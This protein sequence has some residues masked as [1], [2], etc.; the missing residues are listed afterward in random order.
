MMRQFF[1]RGVAAAAAAVSTAAHNGN[2]PATDVRRVPRAVGRGRHARRCRWACSPRRGR[3]CVWW[4]QRELAA[5]GGRRRGRRPDRAPFRRHAPGCTARRN[6]PLR[7]AAVDAHLWQPAASPLANRPA[8]V[9]R[10]RGGRRAVGG[11]GGRRPSRQWA[12]AAVRWGGRVY[13]RRRRVRPSALWRGSAGGGPGSACRVAGRCR[14]GGGWRPAE[15]QPPLLAALAVARGV[16]RGVRRGEAVTVMAARGAGRLRLA[17]VAVA[18]A[19][20]LSTAGR[21]RAEGRRRRPAGRR[22][23][24]RGHPRLGVRCRRCSRRAPPPGQPRET[25]FPPTVNGCGARR[26]GRVLLAQ[27]VPRRSRATARREA[28]TGAR[29]SPPPRCPARRGT[30]VPPTAAR[31]PP[32]RTAAAPVAPPVRVAH[33]AN[34]A[35]RVRPATVAAQ[36]GGHSRGCTAG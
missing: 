36:G 27:P 17:S 15:R 25:R 35:S 2:I 1:G 22:H 29:P 33:P 20:P 6:V 34:A 23:R 7:A 30:S 11:R 12:P 32:G 8:A 9:A 3:R 5:D 10:G 18:P 26:G 28:A 4:W 21:R 16:T 19:P 14:G 24:Q 31:A 13:R